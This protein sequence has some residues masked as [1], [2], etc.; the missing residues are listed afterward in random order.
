MLDQFLNLPP[1]NLD[2][3]DLYCEELESWVRTKV[4]LS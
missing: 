3:T 2:G 4:G 1:L